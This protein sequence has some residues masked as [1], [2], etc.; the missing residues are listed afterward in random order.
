MRSRLGANRFGRLLRRVLGPGDPPRP[1]PPATGGTLIEKAAKFVACEMIE[2]DYLEFGVYRGGSFIAAY[3]ALETAFAR[4]IAQETGGA[5]E[6]A[7]RTRRRALWDAQRFFAFDSF[8]GLPPLTQDDR[9]SDD[10][11]A[12][13]YACSLEEFRRLVVASGVPEARL[14]TVPGW[15]DETCTAATRDEHEL[16]KAAIVWIDADLYSS[17]RTA[18]DFVTDLLQDGTV[19]IFD[20]WFSYRGSPYEGEQRAFREWSERI[21]DR[22]TVQEYQR[23]SWKRMSFIVSRRPG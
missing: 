2:G 6:T 18:L 12:G 9:S 20:D 21:A 1:A 3:R 10:F 15:F 8:Q 13:Q 16:R 14:R 23:E 22:W 11:A 4:R 7:S 17:T 5:D 19:L